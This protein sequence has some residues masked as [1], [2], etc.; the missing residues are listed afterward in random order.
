MRSCAACGCISETHSRT[1][2]VGVDRRELE[3]QLACLDPGEIEQVV[4]EAH[5]VSRRRVDVADV[6]L[7]AVVADRSEPLLHHHF[8]ET[9]NR[10]Q[11]RAHL[12]ADAGEEFGLAR[13]GLHG[14]VARRLQRAFGRLRRPEIAQRRAIARRRVGGDETRQGQRER[15]RLAAPVAAGELLAAARRRLIAPHALEARRRFALALRREQGEEAFARH[16]LGVVAEQG[17]GAAAHGEDAARLVERDDAVGGRIE[18]RLEIARLAFEIA[19]PLLI[20]DLARAAQRQQRRRR[21][22]PFDRVG[23]RID[24]D[25]LAARRDQRNGAAFADSARVCASRPRNMRLR[26]SAARNSARSR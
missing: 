15:K 21:A 11:R 20:F 3:L 12:V 1:I 4:G 6:V 14:G 22:V 7:V 17:L 2:A 23:Q 18:Q 8:G 25:Q 26:P 13:V 9:E 16:F 10:V 24:G 19:H 5:D